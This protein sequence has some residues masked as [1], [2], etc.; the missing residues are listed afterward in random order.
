MS[1]SVPEPEPKI[2]SAPRAMQPEFLDVQQ[3]LDDLQV[4]VV[5]S[6]NRFLGPASLKA[7]P[8]DPNRRKIALA[9]SGG[10]AK[11]AYSAGTI[12][13]L[14]T[15]MRERGLKPDLLVGTSAGALNGYG[16]FVEALG[17]H[18]RQLS[19]DPEIKQPYGTFIAAIWSLL[20]RERRTSRWIA[21]R[22]SWIVD[23]ATRGLS[24]PLR[25]WSL[26]TM[27]LLA[28]LLF[29]P[30]LFVGFMLALG[31]EELLP[32]VLR[33]SAG[34]DTTL[35]LVVL[36]SL[37]LFGLAVMLKALTRAF[38]Q[39]L[40]LDT[41]LLRLLANTG[42]DGDL[43][44]PFLWAPEQ[45]RD[46]AGALS[47]ELVTEWYRR[48]QELPELIIT[49]AD[50]TVGRECLFT[51]V[52][53]ETYRALVEQ[54]WM[55]VQIDSEDDAARE[56]HSIEGALFVSARSLLESVV[57]SA[58]VPGAFPSQRM[59][60]YAPGGAKTAWHRFLD[61]GVLNNSPL[62]LAIDGGASHILSLELDPL[63]QVDALAV[64]DDG[65]SM[66]LLEAGV[67]SYAALLDRAIERD[68]RRTVTWNRFL[69]QRPD[70]ALEPR[71][72]FRRP[73]PDEREKKRIIPIYRIAPKEPTLGTSEFDGRFNKGRLELSLRDVLKQ[74]ALDLKGK[75]IWRAT[76]QSCPCDRS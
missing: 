9:I 44:Q 17:L 20:D 38:G 30:F 64:A 50:I 73:S 74:G 14:L 21:G 48:R 67:E 36:G 11:G 51:L 4:E 57:A 66:N 25:R 55:A 58:A 52:R 46:R 1:S 26:Y 61:G 13:G 47:R 29:N 72:M 19:E 35:L 5:C 49:A 62:H 6:D 32:T 70:A 34:G 39:S 59:K 8:I 41:P 71:S 45:T 22:R 68:M 56:Y 23:L 12:E 16:V 18:N 60:L 33:H 54:G 76:L 3:L 28:T 53:P 31:L 65:R 7:Q 75:P 63:E 42:R 15:R 69:A 27:L 40:F 43:R 37:S 24:T 10:G 2:L